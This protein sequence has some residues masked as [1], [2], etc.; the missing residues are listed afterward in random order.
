MD[1]L[2]DRLAHSEVKAEV[3]LLYLKL[4]N[5]EDFFENV[6]NVKHLFVYLELI[7]FES[8][9]VKGVVDHILQMDGSVVYDTQELNNA[10]VLSF[11]SEKG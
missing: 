5:I 9:H 2:W 10:L 4:H 7:V 11:V 3:L 8:C 1:G 6:S